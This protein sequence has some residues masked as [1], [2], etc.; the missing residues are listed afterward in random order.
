MGKS[1]SVIEELEV[2]KYNFEPAGSTLVC[3]L[4]M[5]TAS[6][7][8]LTSASESPVETEVVSVG[9]KCE[10]V[11]P[12]DK[13]LAVGNYNPFTVDEE[14]FIQIYESQVMLRVLNGAKVS[15]MTRGGATRDS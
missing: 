4:K 10:W 1:K 5:E 13:I 11:K 2:V 12:G 6:G 9:P 14:D 3:K 8:I 15:V 7:I